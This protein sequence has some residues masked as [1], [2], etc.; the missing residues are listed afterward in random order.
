MNE[1]GDIE[2]ALKD[3]LENAKRIAVVGVGYELR[4]DDFV[5]VEV[6]QRLKG[7]VPKNVMLIESET[8]PESFL[9]TITQFN[10]THVVLIDAGLIELEPGQVKIMDTSSALG[11]TTTVSTHTLPLRI[12][13]EYLEKTIGTK[14]MLIIVQPE[15]IDFGEG[16]TKKVRKTAERLAETL[17]RIIKHH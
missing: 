2:D 13:C 17:T 3:W 11:S 15:T 8:V 4:R 9:D 7:K 6:V 14:I 12:F 5:G 16:L 10:P 1:V